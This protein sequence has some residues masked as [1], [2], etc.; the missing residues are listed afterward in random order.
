MVVLPFEPVMATS[1]PRR[2]RQASSISLQTGMPLLAREFQRREVCR[3]SWTDDDQILFEETCV[4]MSSE[5][6]LHTCRA[7][8]RGGFGEF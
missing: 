7:E 2:K 6:Q 8:L 1:L 5:F 4:N 3:H